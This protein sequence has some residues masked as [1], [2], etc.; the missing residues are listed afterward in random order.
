M[1]SDEQESQYGAFLLVTHH[2]SLA[3][4][5]TLAGYTADR[6]LGGSATFSLPSPCP[7]GHHYYD[8]RVYHQRA[9]GLKSFAALTMSERVGRE[10][11][12]MNVRI[13]L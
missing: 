8:C 10:Q 5:L 6:E 7:E 3:T 4:A 13:R 2:L 11:A 9:P 1:T 12:L